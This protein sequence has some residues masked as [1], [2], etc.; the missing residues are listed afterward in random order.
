M[1]EMLSVLRTSGIFFG[2]SEEETEKML[3]CLE[4]RPETYQKDEYILRAGD[5]V[6]A[7][8]VVITGK[9][10]II[11]EDFWG[12]RNILAAVGAGH[13]FAETFACS[14]GAVLN[15][16]VIAETN[17]QVLF[18]N[19]KRILTTCPSTCSHH[20]RMI[21]NL[22]SELAEKNLRLNEKITHLGQRSR[23]A[24][25]LSYLS[26]EAQRHGSA[27]F[28]IAFSRQQLADYLSVDRSGLSM[29]LSRMQ[30]EGL[31]EYRKKHFVLKS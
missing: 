15:V 12:N 27:E 30:E 17:V 26:A 4:V 6:E 20:S 2:I 16:S 22:L 1:K 8:G 25:I 29:E 3:H 31:L 7:F 14:P 18:L 10:M 28:D 9:V 5:R 19:V 24:K 11:Q 23:R 13:C 21:R